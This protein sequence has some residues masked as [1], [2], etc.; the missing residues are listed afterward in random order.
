M[1]PAPVPKSESPVPN[2]SGLV[3]SRR[4]WIETVLKPWCRQASRADLLQAEQDWPNLAGQVDAERTLWVWSWSRFPPLVTENQN[5]LEETH[6]V[7]IA[8]R[9]GTRQSGYPDA[10]QS[11]HGRLV[12]IGESP[13]GRST[14][15]GPFSIDDVRAVE[16]A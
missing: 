9:D 13:V 2:F 1:E 3:A 4:A 7:A 11:R 12:L 15:L 5:G 6:C 14:E 16:R 8:L 10:R